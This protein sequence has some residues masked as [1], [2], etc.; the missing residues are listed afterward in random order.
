[1]LLEAKIGEA[2]EAGFE[3]SPLLEDHGTKQG[4]LHVP[5]GRQP[6]HRTCIEALVYSFLQ[7]NPG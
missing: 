2:S 7:I 3:D 4:E 1:M 6:S 5:L